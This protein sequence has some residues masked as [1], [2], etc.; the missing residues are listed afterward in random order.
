MT[1]DPR[2]GRAPTVAPTARRSG[3]GA[4]RPQAR[5]HSGPLPAAAGPRAASWRC[6]RARHKASRPHA[7]RT[8]RSRHEQVRSARDR[9][10]NSRARAGGYPGPCALRPSC[11]MRSCA[12]P[13]PCGV[14]SGISS[15]SRGPLCS[16]RA[17][18][19]SS[20]N[21][22][23]C[24]KV[25]RANAP[26]VLFRRCCAASRALASSGR[27]AG[28]GACGT[29]CARRCGGGSVARCGMRQGRGGRNGRTQQPPLSDRQRPPRLK[30]SLSAHPSRSATRPSDRRLVSVGC[31]VAGSPAMPELITAALMSG[32]VTGALA[33]TRK[34][35]SSI[36]A[37]RT[38][39]GRSG[40]ASAASTSAISGARPFCFATASRTI[41]VTAACKACFR[42]GG[43]I[44]QDRLHGGGQRLGT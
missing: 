26:S 44:G 33:G 20:G 8:A 21:E 28:N 40:R 29:V 39:C 36:A 23:I 9:S 6:R 14:M 10:R 16:V 2:T 25:C 43:H 42:C 19:G 24:S 38:G 41:A 1:P 18:F 7:R 15:V 27:L 37:A 12:T 3:T 11:S 31:N 17:A 35:R 5:R 30:S 13:V 32:A 22:A 34:E 4:R